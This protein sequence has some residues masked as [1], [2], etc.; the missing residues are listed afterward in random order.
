MVVVYLDSKVLLGVQASIK[1]AGRRHSVVPYIPMEC[2]IPYNVL[3][4]AVI[5]E[6]SGVHLSFELYLRALLYRRFGRFT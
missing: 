5:P 4:R 3:T 6:V 2:L 1:M